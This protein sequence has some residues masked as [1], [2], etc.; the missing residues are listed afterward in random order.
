MAHCFDA[1]LDDEQP[2]VKR[3]LKTRGCAVPTA[4]LGLTKKDLRPH[5]RERTEHIVALEADV[6]TLN[7]QVAT[8]EAK[9]TDTSTVN[10]SLVAILA[11]RDKDVKALSERV[12]RLQHEVDALMDD[13]VALAHLTGTTTPPAA[14][15][16]AASH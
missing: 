7:A 11:E 14:G 3:K 2:W 13:N 5:R 1:M 16:C 9:V 12:T 6:S 15:L 8:L 4:A 10:D